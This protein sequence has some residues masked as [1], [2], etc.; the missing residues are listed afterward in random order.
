MSYRLLPRTATSNFPFLTTF[1]SSKPDRWTINYSQHVSYFCIKH[2]LETAWN[3]FVIKDN[4]FFDNIDTNSNTVHCTI[5]I[6]F[7]RC[8]FI[9]INYNWKLMFFWCWELVYLSVK[10]TFLFSD[11]PANN[12]SRLEHKRTSFDRLFSAKGE[13]NFIKFLIQTPPKESLQSST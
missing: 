7:L 2:P 6:F 3:F 13:F 5:M 1:P 12:I 8:P 10:I 11:P 9:Y 4:V